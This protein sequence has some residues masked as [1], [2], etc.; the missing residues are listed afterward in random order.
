MRARKVDERPVSEEA[1][2]GAAMDNFHVTPPVADATS[3]RGSR[4]RHMVAHDLPI[5]VRYSDGQIG[6]AH[7][8]LVKRLIFKPQFDCPTDLMHPAFSCSRGACL[9]ESTLN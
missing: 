4:A 9:Q 2:N 1:G 7:I 5:A 8:P 6:R 3:V